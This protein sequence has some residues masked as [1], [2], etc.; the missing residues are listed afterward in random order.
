MPSGPGAERGWRDRRLLAAPCEPP[1][2]DTRAESD[3]HQQAR[4]QRQGGPPHKPLAAQELPGG[5]AG[6]EALHEPHLEAERRLDTGHNLEQRVGRKRELLHLGVAARA[7]FD[8][9]E[10]LRPLPS[11]R[12]PQRELRELIGVPGA[13]WPRT[14]FVTAHRWFPSLVIVSRSLERPARIRVFAVPSGMASASL[15]SAAVIP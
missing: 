15:I 6:S 12:D 3:E 8:V 13:F 4:G 2:A 1:G 11:C 7:C 9:G 10:Y 14:H 5:A